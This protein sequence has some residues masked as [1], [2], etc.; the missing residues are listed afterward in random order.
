MKYSR[1]EKSSNDESR[2]LGTVQKPKN[3]SIAY[4]EYLFEQQLLH[5]E[6]KVCDG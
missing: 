3:T 6:S 2:K 5:P 1:S 4:L